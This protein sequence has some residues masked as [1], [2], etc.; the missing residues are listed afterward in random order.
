MKGSTTHFVAIANHFKSKGSGP[1]DGTG[2]GLSNESRVAQAKAL[3]AW[4]GT[5]FGSRPVFLMG[6]FNAYS[7]EDPVRAIE[8]AGYTEVVA[9]YSPQATSYQYGSRM[10]SLDHVFANAAARDLVTGADIWDINAPE[11]V[12]MQYS[13]DGLNV[14][15]FHTDGPWAAS[16]HSPALV[17][18]RST[19]EV[20][21]T[22]TPTPSET[23]TPSVT[24]TPPVTPTTS[25]T[26]TDSATAS[27]SVTPTPSVTA[28]G[29]VAPVPSQVPTVTV[30]PTAPVGTVAPIHDRPE[31]RPGTVP[32]ALPR[33]GA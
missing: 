1:D 8:D 27:P 3:T 14:V 11:S 30:P 29:S 16:D 22:P 9:E 4:A 15:D 10:G 32:T 33:T 13:R 31:H 6:D 5:T 23:P 2:Q 17:G 12:A 24:P 7:R 18:L 20:T 19:P 26:P 28:S 21:T 25:V